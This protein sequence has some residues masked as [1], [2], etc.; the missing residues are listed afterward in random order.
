MSEQSQAQR[1]HLVVLDSGYGD[2]VVERDAARAFGVSVSD[3]GGLCL[4]D[5]L[6]AAD[7]V[8]GVLVSRFELRAGV[9]ARFPTWRVIGRYGS[10]FDNVDVE[11]ATRAGIALINVPDYCV[12]E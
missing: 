5:A 6:A 2:V 7:G 11:A 1:L 12:E 10:G 4:A 8:D 3:A 9:I